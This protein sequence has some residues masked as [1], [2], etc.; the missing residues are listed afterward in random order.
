MLTCINYYIIHFTAQRAFQYLTQGKRSKLV[1]MLDTPCLTCKFKCLKGIIVI[2]VFWNDCFVCCVTHDD[3]TFSCQCPST[4]NIL[5]WYNVAMKHTGSWLSSSVDRQFINIII[6][7]MIIIII[8]TSS[9]TDFAQVAIQRKADHS[10]YS[11][12]NNLPLTPPA[13]A[14]KIIACPPT[15]PSLL[16]WEKKKFF[17]SLLWLGDK[18]NWE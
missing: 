9:C 16:P 14:H 8:S 15:L 3:V 17:L 2:V 11:V 6:I 10:I 12:Q 7:I 5:A 1:N 13:Q 4:M 18:G